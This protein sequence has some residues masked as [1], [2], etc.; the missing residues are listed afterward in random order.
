MDRNAI[1]P[2]QFRRRGRPN[3]IGLVG[4][5]G[6][7]ERGHVIDIDAEFRHYVSLRKR[8]YATIIA[9]LLCAVIAAIVQRPSFLLQLPAHH[10]VKL[11]AG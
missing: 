3:R 2:T 11:V 4:P 6:L 5:P 9:A 8:I 1:R 10:G 7:A